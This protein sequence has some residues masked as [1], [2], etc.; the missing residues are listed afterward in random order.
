MPP[1][2][3]MA[4]TMKHFPASFTAFATEAMSFKMPEVVSLWTMETWVISGSSPRISAVRSA[5]GI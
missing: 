4:S 2:V 5:E 3:D 1:K